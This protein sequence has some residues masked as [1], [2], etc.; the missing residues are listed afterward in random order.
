MRYS[1][2]FTA[3]H[4]DSASEWQLVNKLR[5]ISSDGKWKFTDIE[6]YTTVYSFDTTSEEA[7][8]LALLGFEIRSVSSHEEAV[9]FYRSDLEI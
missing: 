1:L 9:A 7:M 6:D 2:L 3:D 4:A 8:V 5:G